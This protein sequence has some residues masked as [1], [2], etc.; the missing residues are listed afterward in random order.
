MKY[1]IFGMIF[2]KLS[3][4]GQLVIP[5]KI[6]ELTNIEPGDTIKFSVQANQIILERIETIKDE[7][8]V[9]FLKQGK[10]F[11]KDLVQN[12]RDEWE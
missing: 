6:R 4:R 2:G 11:E 9:E 5:K 12:L 7:N 10:P 3:K 8:I 1:V